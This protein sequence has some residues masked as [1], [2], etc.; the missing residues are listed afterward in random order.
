[1]DYELDGLA[2]ALASGALRN[3]VG[4]EGFASA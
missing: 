3:A 4:A 1:M 2:D